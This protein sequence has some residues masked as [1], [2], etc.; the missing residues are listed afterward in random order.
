MDYSDLGVLERIAD[1]LQTQQRQAA[2]SA[3]LQMVHYGIIDYLSRANR[4]SNTPVAVAQWLGLT[5]GT[6]SQSISLL[7]EKG[8]LE[9]RADAQD[10]RCQQLFLTA[11]GRSLVED[12]HTRLRALFG[13]V[14]INGAYSRIFRTILND[15]LWQ[16]QEK[17]GRNGFGPCGTCRHHRVTE[18]GPVCTLKKETLGAADEG[19]ICRTH[20]FAV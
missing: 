5:K 20:E 11:S 6:V 14:E 16:L 4:W 9:K 8:Y 12:G 7:V 19:K 13:G 2:S 3:G 17:T 1:I 18:E 10:A 15:I